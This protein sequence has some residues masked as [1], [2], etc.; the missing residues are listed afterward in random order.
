[1]NE[2]IIFTKIHYN[3][4]GIT[5]LDGCRSG[6]RQ[7]RISRIGRQQSEPI[8]HLTRQLSQCLPLVLAA[9][10]LI[11]PTHAQTSFEANSREWL[12]EGDKNA[13]LMFNDAGTVIFHLGLRAL[14]YSK[15]ES[16]LAAGSLMGMVGVLK[17]MRDPAVS[18]KDLAAN[19]LDITAGMGV[20]F[21][22][23]WDR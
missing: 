11:T 9:T 6:G 16:M 14:G 5:L 15:W 10:L 18:E 20:V 8:R 2:R 22:L 3:I 12:A 1:M 23:D 17:E 7:I 19:G 4:D 13:H 21:I